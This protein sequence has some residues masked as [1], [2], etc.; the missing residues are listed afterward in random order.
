MNKT[1]KYIVFC[2]MIIICSA[3]SEPYT[4]EIN[5]YENILIIDGL[6]TDQPNPTVKLSRGFHYSESE[7]IPERRA[8]VIIRD[9]QENVI[10]LYEESPGIYYPLDSGF[11]GVIGRSY[12]VFIYT[13]DD[14]RYESD[15]VELKKVPGIE[16]LFAE[17]GEKPVEKDLEKGFHIYVDTYDPD[18]ETR[19]YRYDFE[20]TWEFTVPYPSRFELVGRSLQLRSI[21][22]YLCWRTEYSTDILLVSTEKMESD[23]VRHFPVHFVSIIGNRLSRRYSILVK[24]YSLSREA[25][26]FW[27]QLKIN[28]QNLGT[29]FDKQPA[30]IFGNVH[31]LGGNESPVLGFFEASSMTSKRLFLENADLPPNVRIESEFEYCRNEYFI[32]ETRRALNYALSGNCVVKEETS[33][34]FGMGI[35]TDHKC[36]DCTFTGSNI[37]PDFW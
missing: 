33:D 3:C 17:F 35:I 20:E 16:N 36:C 23:I 9:D 32:V 21:I 29:L 15:F 25:Y 18:N 14:Q 13:E 11:K 8:T 12:Q 4:P 5:K 26:I 27:N 6:I 24:Q 2:L 31:N 34:I 22:P 7:S 37:K 1:F 10:S 30:Q 28:N 19:Y